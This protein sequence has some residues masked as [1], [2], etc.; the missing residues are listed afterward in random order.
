MEGGDLGQTTK[1]ARF[2]K[3]L[4]ISGGQKGT[5]PK[6]QHR[7]H[8]HF[9]GA[10]LLLLQILTVPPRP[11]IHFQTFFPLLKETGEAKKLE[12]EIFSFPAHDV[13]A[14][15]G[16][17][18]VVV[19]AVVMVVVVAAAIATMRFVNVAS[20]DGDDDD[21]DD[22]ASDD[23]DD[24]DGGGDDGPKSRQAKLFQNLSSRIS[25]PKSPFQI[26]LILSIHGVYIYSYTYSYT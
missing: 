18:E 22:D 7:L 25:V 13:L 4:A 2:Y 16:V 12:M 21:E 20:D 5:K 11:Q 24:A 14:V 19:V 15:V 23:V 26:W 9:G 17:V 6:I 8:R 1:H 10:V 3:D